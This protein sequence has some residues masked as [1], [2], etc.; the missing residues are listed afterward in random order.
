MG[1]EKNNFIKYSYPRPNTFNTVQ[2]SLIRNNKWEFE[3]DNGMM[4][5]DKS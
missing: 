5:T 3:D 2:I 1:L 4:K